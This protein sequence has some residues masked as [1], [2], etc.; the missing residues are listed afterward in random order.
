MCVVALFS[1]RSPSMQKGAPTSQLDEKMTEWHLYIIQCSDDS[2]YTGITTN[3]ERRFYEHKMQG[4]KSAKYV[5]GRKPLQLVF[6][7][8]IGDKGEAYRIEKKV[9]GLSKEKKKHLIC[10]ELTIGDLFPK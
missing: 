1:C 7:A 2:F 5:K 8:K 3:V 4:R 10:G 6:S 9:K